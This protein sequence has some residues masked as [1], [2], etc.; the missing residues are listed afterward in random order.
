MIERR[1]YSGVIATIKERHRWIVPATLAYLLLMALFGR[2]IL[3][4]FGP[5][6]E[7]GY[8]ALCWIAGGATVSVWFA[9][10]P[11]YLKF[12]RLVLGITAAAGGLNALLLALLGPGYGATGAAAAYGISLAA[13]AVT[14]LVL[15]LGAAKQLRQD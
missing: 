10:A 12:V 6:F 3:Q 11:N 5:E 4:L 1:D 14:F 8:A 15:G 2:Q 13:M 9:M 7:E